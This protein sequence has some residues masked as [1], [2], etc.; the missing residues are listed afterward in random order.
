M[1]GIL[2][3]GILHLACSIVMLPIADH[4][5]IYRWST[6]ISIIFVIGWII[7]I[8]KCKELWAIKIYSVFWVLMGTTA[9]R[10]LHFVYLILLFPL[11]GLCEPIRAD[12]PNWCLYVPL[13]GLP[14]LCL[15]K[16]Y[17]LTRKQ[18]LQPFQEE[19]KS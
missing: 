13:Y 6:A 5:D 2:A 1:A 4:P 17:Y 12:L 16:L 9:L 8:L 10:I 15:A 3:A 19:Q 18:R 11:F 7:I 14:L